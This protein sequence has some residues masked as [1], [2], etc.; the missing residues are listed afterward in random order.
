M[1]ARLY[2]PVINHLGSLIEKKYNLSCYLS[3]QLDFQ[4]RVNSRPG[5]I[6]DEFDL[7]PDIPIEGTTGEAPRF[8]FCF[9]FGTTFTGE[10]SPTLTVIFQ[11][12]TL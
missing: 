12:L 4:E 2:P 8:I 6:M 11:V 10:F 3:Q 9:D 1:A 7:G 5:T